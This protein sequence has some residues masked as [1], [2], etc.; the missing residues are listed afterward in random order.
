MNRIP[1]EVGR[2]R[3]EGTA[4]SVLKESA[5]STY[6]PAAFSRMPYRVCSDGTEVP[7]HEFKRLVVDEGRFNFHMDTVIL[8][9][10]DQVAA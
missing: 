8:V 5:E 4:L 10:D 2:S 6:L 7:L 1:M 9:L 3:H